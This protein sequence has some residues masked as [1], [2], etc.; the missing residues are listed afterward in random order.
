MLHRPDPDATT[1]EAAVLKDIDEQ[2]DDMQKSLNMLVRGTN[3]THF[4]QVSPELRSWIQDHCKQHQDQIAVIKNLIK[5]AHDLRTAIARKSL[6]LGKMINAFNIQSRG[7]FFQA[8]TSIIDTLW[9]D[10]EEMRHGEIQ[11]AAKAIDAVTK[12]LARLDHIGQHVRLVSLNA[13]V[14]SA[15]VGDAARGLAVIAQE[16]KALAEEIQS[17]ASSAQTDIDSLR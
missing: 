9:L 6:N 1:D 14:E 13:S 17:L 2:L 3:G 12:T 4:D 15:R 7:P 5:D 8:V 16:F 10:F 11:R